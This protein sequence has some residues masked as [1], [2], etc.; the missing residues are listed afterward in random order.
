MMRYDVVIAT[1]AEED[2]AGIHDY[3]EAKESLERADRT[4]SS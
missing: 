4:V 1:D 2:I 3:R